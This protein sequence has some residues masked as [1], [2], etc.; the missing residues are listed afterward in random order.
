MRGEEAEEKSDSG[1]QLAST[2]QARQMLAGG[3][4]QV[5]SSAQLSCDLPLP[6]RLVDADVG[7]SIGRSLPWRSNDKLD[8]VE[9]TGWQQ[10]RVLGH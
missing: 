7:E 6:R 2:T 10:T 1:Q 5:H 4:G 3:T 9:Q 8:S